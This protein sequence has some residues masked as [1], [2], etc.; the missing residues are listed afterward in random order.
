MKNLAKIAAQNGWE[1]L[2]DSDQYQYRI[3]IA[4][5]SG[6]LY[7][8]AQAKSHRKDAGQWQCSCL[9]FRRHRHCKHIDAMRPALEAASS[10]RKEI[11]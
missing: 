10:Q 3:Q 2:P 5:S 8:V 6:N 9:G 11:A 4:G 1:L 7:V